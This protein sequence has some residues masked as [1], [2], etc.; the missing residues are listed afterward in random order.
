MHNYVNDKFIFVYLIKLGQNDSKAILFIFMV[1]VQMNLSPY[2]SLVIYVY[3]YP[4]IH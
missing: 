1:V 2:L 4:Y 3:I